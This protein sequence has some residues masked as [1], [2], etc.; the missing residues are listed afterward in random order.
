MRK[1]DLVDD[2]AEKID[3]PKSKIS[4]V[5]DL[6]LEEMILNLAKGEQVQLMGFGT[7]KA[8]HKPARTG[9]RPGTGEP[10]EIP[11]KTIAKFTP[12]K[13]LKSL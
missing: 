1:K 6:F 10:M 3:L 11:A 9:T 4:E 2:L 7:F 5:V 13:R 8:H 12:S